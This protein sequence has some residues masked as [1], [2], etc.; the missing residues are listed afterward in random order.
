[1]ATA[2]RCTAGSGDAVAAVLDVLRIEYGVERPGQALRDFAS[3]SSDGFAKRVSK[4]RRKG[5]GR[6][7]PVGLRE[8]RE[9]HEAESPPILELRARLREA[10]QTIARTAHEAWKLTPHDLVEMRATAPPRM[11][12][13]LDLPARA[14]S[15]SD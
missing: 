10:E 4:R 11:P 8:L 13:G 2:V 6:L 7:S 3:L 5:V 15:G 1:M 9:L 14:D 12:P